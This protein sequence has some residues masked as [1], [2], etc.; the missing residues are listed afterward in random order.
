MFYKIDPSEV[1][2]L[3]G[4]FGDAF[5]QYDKMFEQRRV[6]GWKTALTQVGNL[7]GWHLDNNSNEAQV[8][9]EIVRSIASHTNLVKHPDGIESPVQVPDLSSFPS[10]VG[11]ESHVQEPHLSSSPSPVGIESLVQEP[12]LS[13]LPS[14]NSEQGSNSSISSQGVILFLIGSVIGLLQLHDLFET[15]PANMWISEAA[16]VIF[17]LSYATMTRINGTRWARYSQIIDSFQALSGPLVPVSLS[18]IHLP[19]QLSWLFYIIWAFL[20]FIV[21]AF[22]W[23]YPEGEGREAQGGQMPFLTPTRISFIQ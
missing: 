8:I 1:R 9:D 17:C 11:I 15:Y 5:A 6:E 22:T 2:H 4:S 12:Q 7:S 20:V 3:K 18:S 21:A 14:R 23:I 16:L 10:P 19:H 13:S